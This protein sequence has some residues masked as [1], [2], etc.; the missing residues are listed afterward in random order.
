MDPEQSRSRDN[1][2]A[3]ELAEKKEETMHR[4]AFLKST[5]M[6]PSAGIG[7]IGLGGYNPGEVVRNETRNLWRTNQ[8]ISLPFEFKRGIQFDPPFGHNWIKWASSRDQRDA[9]IAV[10][11]SLTATNWISED[12][13][14]IAKSTEGRGHSG[15]ENTPDTSYHIEDNINHYTKSSNTV[16]MT[17]GGGIIEKSGEDSD[18]GVSPNELDDFRELIH[19]LT[20]PTRYEIILDLIGHRKQMP[21]LEEL[22]YYNN[23]KQSTIRE[24]L[25]K[26]ITAGFVTTESWDKGHPERH[27]D[28]P[29]TFFRLTSDGKEFIMS[30]GLLPMS[31]KELQDEYARLD[32]PPKIDALEKRERPDPSGTSWEPTTPTAV[33]RVLNA[34]RGKAGPVVAGTES[35]STDEHE[36]AIPVSNVKTKLNELREYIDDLEEDMSSNARMAVTQVGRNNRSNQDDE[37]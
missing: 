19:F 31:E 29:N 34:N 5:A 7:C 35:E 14:V 6:A 24:H 16:I 26:L 1:E 36:P 9:E 22:T 25:D 28:E 2:P 4:R 13:K 11:F 8:L 20:Q 33:A 17:D 30:N 37:N 32:K 3:S 10:Q 23:K 27:R 21:T 15:S 12:D 18:D